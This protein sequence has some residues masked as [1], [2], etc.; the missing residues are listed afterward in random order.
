M[1]LLFSLFKV[2]DQIELHCW[3]KNDYFDLFKQFV[4]K[5]LINIYLRMS[6]KGKEIPPRSSY[7]SDVFIQAFPIYFDI[8]QY[9]HQGATKMSFLAKY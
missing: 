2:N 1:F 8:L 7:K 9:P 5:T 4:R 3:D 6:R